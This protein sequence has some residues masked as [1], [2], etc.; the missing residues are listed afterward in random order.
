MEEKYFASNATVAQA[1]GVVG[2]GA[3]T[4]LPSGHDVMKPWARRLP[5]PPYDRGLG[6]CSIVCVSVILFERIDA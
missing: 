2:V 5:S 6:A 4:R 1:A 3:A